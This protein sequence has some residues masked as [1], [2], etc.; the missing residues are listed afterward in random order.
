VTA[1]S[2][3]EFPPAAGR[4]SGAAA[5]RVAAL[6]QSATLDAYGAGAR[7]HDA[8]SAATASTA[9]A[10]IAAGNALAARST[11][12]AAA[13]GSTKHRCTTFNDSHARS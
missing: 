13:A 9:I 3:P 11:D 10:T 5:P 2:I 12:P 1:A 8:I 4:A 6:H 7:Q